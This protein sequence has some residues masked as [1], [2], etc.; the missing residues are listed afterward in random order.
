MWAECSDIFGLVSRRAKVR[1]VS[2]EKPLAWTK[3][4]EDLKTRRHKDKRTKRPKFT[5]TKMQKYETKTRQQ[6]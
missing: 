2:E 1:K 4:L 6:D 3:R 5:K